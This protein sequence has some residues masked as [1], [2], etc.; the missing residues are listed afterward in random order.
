MQ[1]DVD[2]AA[3]R[4]CILPGGMAQRPAKRSPYTASAV[5]SV[6][7]QFGLALAALLRITPTS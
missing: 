5:Q 6:F 1:H 2:T 3:E 4:Q 7:R